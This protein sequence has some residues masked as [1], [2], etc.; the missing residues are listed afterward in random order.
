[1]VKLLLDRQVVVPLRVLKYTLVA[2]T[3]DMTALESLVL[4]T[5]PNLG[6]GLLMTTR[7]PILKASL[8]GAVALPPEFTRCVVVPEFS[9]CLAAIRFCSTRA[10]WRR[11]R[12]NC[13]ISESTESSDIRMIPAES[14]DF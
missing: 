13:L 11:R 3:L 5:L 6:F 14:I 7:P 8:S 12:S 1:M 9:L 2:V 10:S 4:T